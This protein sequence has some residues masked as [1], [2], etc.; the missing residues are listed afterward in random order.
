M[1]CEIKAAE[2]REPGTPPWQCVAI[3][4]MGMVGG[5]LGM[6][7]R[8]RG[9]ARRVVGVARRAETVELAVRLG[10]ADTATTDLLQGVRGADL[11]VLAA[12]VLTMLELAE[13]MAPALAAGCVVTDVGSTKS[14]LLERL[15]R[16]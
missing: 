2:M 14:L 1:S 7:L 4:G 12:P 16:L 8:A 13:Q 15:P 5:S 6:A 10:A 11:V 3:V 9:L